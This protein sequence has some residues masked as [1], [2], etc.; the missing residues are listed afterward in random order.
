[1]SVDQPAYPRPQE[2][3]INAPF[4]AAWHKGALALQRCRGCGKAIYY[5]RAMCPYCWSDALDWFE[6]SGRGHVYSFTVVRQAYGEWKD[7]VPYVIG[8]VELEDGPRV[9]TNIV[10]CDPEAIAIGDEV[11]LHVDHAASGAGVYRFAPVRATSPR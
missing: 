8:Y 10:D 2:D 9:L 3:A 5:P 1:M 11:V 6:A 4:L 7:A